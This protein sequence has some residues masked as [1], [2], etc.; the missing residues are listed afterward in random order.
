MSAEIWYLDTSAFVKLVVREPES[1]AL[2][3]WCGSKSLASSDLLRTEARRALVGRP[4]SERERCE[5]LIAALTLV[6][7]HAD[8]FDQAGRLPNSNLRSWDALHLAAALQI[9]EE[10]A[11]IATY[12][13]R[14]TEAATSM[15][16]AVARPRD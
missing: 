2:R 8:V 16:V 1:E 10:L 15:G 12:D 9:G 4:A 5:S 13:Q 7:L 11:G 6:R 3:A 14:L